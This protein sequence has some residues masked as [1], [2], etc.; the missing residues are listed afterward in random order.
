MARVD[1][2][3]EMPNLGQYAP[4]T[5]T[6]PAIN[7]AVILA[8]LSVLLPCLG[9]F[10]VIAGWLAL[11][12]IRDSGGRFSGRGAAIFSIFAGAFMTGMTL[13]AVL[14]YFAWEPFIQPRLDGFFDRSAPVLVAPPPNPGAT[15]TPWGPQ[16]IDAEFKAGG[17]LEG[18]PVIEIRSGAMP[19]GT[20]L[21]LRLHCAGA[22]VSMVS[23]GLMELGSAT[24]G[25]LTYDGTRLADGECV[26]RVRL[27]PRLQAPNI[28]ERLGAEGQNMDSL[29]LVEEAGVSIW[30]VP[31][32]FRIGRALES[33]IE[34]EERL[35]LA[36]HYRVFVDLRDRLRRRRESM[37]S[38][39]VKGDDER[40]VHYSARWN[41]QRQDAI[42][43][44]QDNFGTSPDDYLGLKPAAHLALRKLPDLLYREWETIDAELSGLGGTDSVEQIS[45]R[46][47]DA[48]GEVAELLK[49][50]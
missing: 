30:E 2:P 48:F 29:N 36:D 25:P 23:S 15:P 3:A 22:P 45:E 5:K 27:D 28:K 20:R 31:V 39:G 19:A 32:R 43:A 12:E 21:E 41:Q 4:R 7:S 46:S 40:W 34:V 38:R 17:L 50:E 8:V 49:I 14:V 10:A 47:D 11:D 24:F 16:V 18:M 33:E 37:V 13:I 26:G 6:A 42:R 44:F 1:M 9:P 35:G